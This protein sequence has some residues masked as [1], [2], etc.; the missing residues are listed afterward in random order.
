MPAPVAW[1][2]MALPVLRAESK[3][4][5]FKAGVSNPFGQVG[6]RNHGR[7]RRWTTG[8]WKRRVGAATNPGP[9]RWAMPTLSVPPCR[10]DLK[11]LIV[12]WRWARSQ[13]LSGCVAAAHEGSEDCRLAARAIFAT[14]VQSST[15]F[16]GWMHGFVIG[17]HRRNSP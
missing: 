5:I 16:T 10:L 12:I 7:D 1:D 8:E 11:G 17:R 2:D 15:E 4:S 14:I 6:Q 3:K 9:V 13:R